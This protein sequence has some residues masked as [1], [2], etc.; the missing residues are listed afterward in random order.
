M[1]EIDDGNGSLYFLDA[2]FRTI[3]TFLMSVVLAIVCARSNI[4]VAV[5]SS[6]IEAI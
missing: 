1:K 6:E 2:P 5:V 3:K 4:A